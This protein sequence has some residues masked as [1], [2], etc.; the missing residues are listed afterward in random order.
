[1][2]EQKI[3]EAMA[4]LDGYK[5]DSRFGLW[6]R[7]EGSYFILNRKPFSELPRYDSHDDVQRVIDGLDD[8]EIGDYHVALWRTTAP[9]GTLG[10]FHR[11]T[12]AQK[13]EAILK[14]KG[15]WEEKIER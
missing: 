7:G 1:M 8:S 12:P 15:L 14:T 13:C 4:R 9:I 2:N 10:A 3:R 5:L 11:A 6:G